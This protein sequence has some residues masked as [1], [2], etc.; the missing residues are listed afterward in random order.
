MT[1]HNLKLKKASLLDSI[2]TAD[3]RVRWIESEVK[4]LVTA[5]IIAIPSYTALRDTTS[6]PQLKRA[7]VRAR[8]FLR[9]KFRT[10]LSRHLRC[11]YPQSGVHH[12]NPPGAVI[13]GTCAVIWLSYRLLFKAGGYSFT[14]LVREAMGILTKSINFASDVSGR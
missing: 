3:R 10:L 4:V 13:F 8:G 11:S 12:R 5:E 2:F 9:M 7:C 6:S 14:G 1:H